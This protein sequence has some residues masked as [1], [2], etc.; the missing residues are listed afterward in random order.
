[1][2]ANLKISAIFIVIALLF[3]LAASP[4][5]SWAIDVYEGVPLL[6][7]AYFSLVPKVAIFGLLL[8]LLQGPF[9]AILD[10]LQP[11]IYLSGLASV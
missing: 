9:Y 1:M 8:V 5:H 6:V 3:K 11:L 7:T 10:S 4:F 2:Q